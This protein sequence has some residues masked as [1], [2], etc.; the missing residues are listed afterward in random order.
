VTRSP[1]HC[2][3]KPKVMK[4]AKRTAFKMIATSV[5]TLLQTF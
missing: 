4:S 3:A 5:Q 1:N 2:T